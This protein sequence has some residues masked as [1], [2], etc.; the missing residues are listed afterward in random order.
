MKKLKKKSEN[1]LRQMKIKKKQ[2]SK[3]YPIQQKQFTLIQAYL[4]K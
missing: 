4:K 3:I 2:F 1:T